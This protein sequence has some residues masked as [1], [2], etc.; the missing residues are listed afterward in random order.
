MKFD[1]YCNYIFVENLLM[2][3]IVEHIEE[4]LLDYQLMKF[5]DFDIDIVVDFPAD[6]FY[7]HTDCLHW[8]IEHYYSHNSQFHTYFNY[9]DRSMILDFDYIY[10]FP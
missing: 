3:Y 1:Y 8:S 10:H 2:S 4:S 6:E 5:A 9:F 7:K